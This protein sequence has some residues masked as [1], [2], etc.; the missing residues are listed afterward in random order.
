M[1]QRKMKPRAVSHDLLFGMRMSPNEDVKGLKKP[2][3]PELMNKY[4]IIAVDEASISNKMLTEYLRTQKARYQM[5]KSWILDDAQL[6]QWRWIA[7][8]WSKAPE[9]PDKVLRRQ[10]NPY[11]CSAHSQKRLFACQ[12]IAWTLIRQ[13]F[14]QTLN[15]NQYRCWSSRTIQTE[16]YSQKLKPNTKWLRAKQH[17]EP[18]ESHDSPSHIDRSQPKQMNAENRIALSQWLL[19]NQ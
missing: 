5:S 16:P 1:I 14:D 9:W 13:Q 19:R 12:T 3:R 2:T 15:W 8:V 18:I 7:C 10:P 17:S 4:D 6:N 11:V